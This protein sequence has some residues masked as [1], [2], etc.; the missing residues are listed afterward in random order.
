MKN[1]N[2]QE[3]VS[4][5]QALVELETI[6]GKLEQ[7]NLALEDSLELFERGVALARQCKTKLDAAQVRVAKLVK[8]KEGL[9]AE[10]EQ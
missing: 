8:D 10:E 6:V 2:K 3:E 9:F 1:G 4:F 7:G 5:E